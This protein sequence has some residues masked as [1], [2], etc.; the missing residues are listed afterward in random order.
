MVNLIMI[1]N[2][3]SSNAHAEA[4]LNDLINCLT[5]EIDGV[6]LKVYIIT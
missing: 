2:I 3:V 4:P 1:L 5:Q 6:L